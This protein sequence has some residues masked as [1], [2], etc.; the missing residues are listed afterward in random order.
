MHEQL[1]H[2]VYREMQHNTAGVTVR[3]AG[4]T[5]HGLPNFFHNLTPP[6]HDLNVLTKEKHHKDTTGTGSTNTENAN[7]HG[8]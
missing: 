7:H 2:W 1:Q 8:K 6:D 3:N 5:Y 4:G